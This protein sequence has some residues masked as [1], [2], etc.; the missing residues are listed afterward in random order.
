MLFW[1]RGFSWMRGCILVSVLFWAQGASAD[2]IFMKNG[3]ELKGLVVEKHF[4]RVLLSTESGE[5]HVLL[6]EIGQIQY[7]EP[8]QNFLEAGKSFETSGKLEEALAYYE[9]AAELNPEFEEAKAAA[10]GVRSR[11]WAKVTEGPRGEMERQQILYDR[12]GQGA[13]P[14]SNEGR[15]A[16]FKKR[17]Q[18]LKEGLGLSLQKEGDWIELDAVSSKKPATVAGLKKSDRLVSIDGKSLRYL[19]VD[20][21]SNHLLEPRFANFTLDFE[22]DFFL[23]REKGSL[24]LKNLGLKLKLEYQGIVIE[25]VVP[26]SLAAEVG[27]KEQDLLTQVDGLPT[28]Y[29]PLKK[30]IRSIE[31]LPGK[32]P[33]TLTVRRSAHL[34]RK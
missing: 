22:R 18:A 1:I 21:V 16:A 32:S 8:E 30:V 7:A 31:D 28:R 6:A 24:S 20:A 12:W 3:K 15:E 29:M 34:S 11:L 25:E 13:A 23:P 17:R 10:I 9:K 14:S 5:V 4:D 27:L 33:V 19:G 26:A 2:T